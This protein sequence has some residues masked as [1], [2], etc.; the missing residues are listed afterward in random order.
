MSGPIGDRESATTA[1]V[2]S[3]T[4]MEAR[5]NAPYKRDQTP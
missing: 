1:S 5:P 2:Y 3:D 4:S